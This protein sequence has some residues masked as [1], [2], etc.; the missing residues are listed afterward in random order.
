MSL[1]SEMHPGIS[2]A[3]LAAL[4][5]FVLNHTMLRIKNPQVSLNLYTRVMDMRVLR[6]L[7]FSEMTFSLYFLAP[8]DAE[9]DLP[10]EDGP[11]TERTFSQCDI[12]ELTHNGGPENDPALAYHDGNAQAQEFGHTCFS[13]PDL[14]FIKD[15]DGYWIEIVQPS[16]L[17]NLGCPS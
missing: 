12:F 13:V 10:E 6:R 2:S 3:A 4:N 11:R 7:D 1:H 16:L 17:T 8:L 14:A 15:P 5:G 9:A